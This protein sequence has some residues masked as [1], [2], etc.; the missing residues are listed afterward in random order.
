MVAS[1]MANYALAL[2]CEARRDSGLST[3]PVL[4]TAVVANVLILGVFK[5]ANFAVENVSA[6][7][8]SLGLP[9][10]PS[11]GIHLPIGVS[12]FTFQAFSYVIDVQR[13]E[14]RA[15]RNPLAIALFVSLFP[16]LIAGPIVR[17]S[18]IASEIRSREV[19]L[20]DF[21]SGVSRFIQGLA[22]KVLIADLV[23][24]PADGIFRLPRAELSA[25]PAFV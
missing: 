18:T 10:I 9:S 12:F 15:N 14:T 7:S 19:R 23:A 11:P 20:H 8:V 22:K 2:W 17:Y 16:Q 6:L 4:F 25:P 24:R 21:S 3:G 13:K 1:I 5:Y